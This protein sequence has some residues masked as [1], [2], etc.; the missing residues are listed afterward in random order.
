MADVS[1][2]TVR[3]E[4]DY[5]RRLKILAVTEGKTVQEIVG[6]LVHAYVLRKEQGDG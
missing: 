4:A 5:L 3:I 6:G 2:L 1:K